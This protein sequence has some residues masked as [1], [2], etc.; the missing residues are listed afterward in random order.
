M[1]TF[2]PQSIRPKREWVIVLA[3]K[4]RERTGGG[5]FLPGHETGIEK[6]TEGAG[7]IIALGS[8]LKAEKLNLSVGQRVVYR[9]F[10]KHANPIPNN[11]KWEDGSEKRYFLM[12][13]DD[14]ISVISPG[15]DVGVFSGRPMVPEA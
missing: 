7:E 6:V 10:L 5:I 11:E 15:V 14:L 8:G 2:D 3:D 4:R 13:I 1:K 9:D 12:A